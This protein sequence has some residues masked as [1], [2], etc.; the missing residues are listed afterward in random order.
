[1]I[2][3]TLYTQP[4]YVLNFYNY[5]CLIKSKCLKLVTKIE[6]S[7]SGSPPHLVWEWKTLLLLSQQIPLFIQ[8]FLHS[9]MS[10]YH[11]PLLTLT[12]LSP[13]DPI[14]STLERE[15]LILQAHGQIFLSYTLSSFLLQRRPGIHLLNQQDIIG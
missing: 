4:L 15:L 10:F 9:Q 8:L 13:M 6:D 1:M 12:P 3:L 14:S 7:S 11:I 2:L 5:L